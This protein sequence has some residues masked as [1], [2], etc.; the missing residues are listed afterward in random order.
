VKRPPLLQFWVSEK[1]RGDPL[2]KNFTR[3]RQIEIPRKCNAASLASVQHCAKMQTV[4]RLTGLIFDHYE[5][6]HAQ[7]KRV[8]I[9]LL[10]QWALNDELPKGYLVFQ[11]IVRIIARAAEHERATGQRY[12]PPE[13]HVRLDKLDGHYLPG[14]PHADAL[15]IAKELC[16]FE[17]HFSFRK[18]AVC[19]IVGH[20]AHL[21]PQSIP[22]ACNVRPDV[23]GLMITCATLKRPPILKL[24][25]PKPRPVFR[26]GDRRRIDVKFY[27]V[28]GNL[29]PA[30]VTH[31]SSS[32]PSSFYGEPRCP[33]SWEDPTIQTV[34]KQRAEY[35]I[36]WRAVEMLR[37]QLFDRLRDHEALRP[38]VPS[39]PWAVEAATPRTPRILPAQ[40]SETRPTQP[41]A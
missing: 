1:E 7:M 13:L 15:A 21:D 24:D 31:W 5:M 6:A 34:A 26:K 9:D 29:I 36:W 20:L 17:R 16:R 23:A 18:E 4:A 32:R 2:V 27:D 28:E 12:I 39:E 41:T 8:P 22:A 10:L 14:E 40:A 30:N 37:L 11:K 35:A 25:H 3:T 38:D 33:L 19:S